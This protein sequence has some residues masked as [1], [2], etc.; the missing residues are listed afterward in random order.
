MDKSKAAGAARSVGKEAVRAVTDPRLWW[1]WL[2]IWTEGSPA[3]RPCLEEVTLRDGT[4][5]W[6]RPL[7]HTDREAHRQ[8]YLRLSADSKYSR[9]LTE[10]PEL[11]DELLQRL[12]DDVDGVDH[13][14]YYLFLDTSAL[15]V[16]IGRI[17]RDPEHPDTADVAVTVQ[18]AHQRRGIATALL[19]VLVARRPAGVTRL[20]T[21]VAA[22]NA[23]SLAMLR[24]LGP[25]QIDRAH[26]MA[27]VRV[28]LTGQGAHQLADL[29]SGHPQAPW[30]HALSTRDRICPWL[31]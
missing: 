16:A 13:I 18:D 8:A 19:A 4:R 15:P 23:A 9:F 31:T 25:T 21:V 20:Q 27:D 1:W 6:I 30:R 12:V 17:V 3:D 7:L 14:A 11:S 28:D 29:P 10:L 26:G 22:D 24:R 2:P 5:A